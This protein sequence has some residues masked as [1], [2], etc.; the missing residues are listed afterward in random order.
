M[1]DN[2][3]VII[4]SAKNEERYIEKA[5]RSVLAQTKL[6]ER[7]VIVSDGSTDGTD[8]IILKYSK[9]NSLISYVRRESQNTGRDF[10]SKVYALQL[11]YKIMDTNDYNFIGHLDADISL[12]DDYYEKI[13]D[14]FINKENLGLA[15]GFVYEPD[16]CTFSRLKFNNSHSVPGAVQ[17]FRRRCYEEIGAFLPLR[18]GGEDW[19]AE[20]KSRMLGWEVQSYP[21]LKVYHHKVGRTRGTMKE[22]I[23]EGRMDYTLG[24]HPIYEIMKCLSRMKQKPYI[25]SG[26][27]RLLSFLYGYL[28][29][30]KR[31]VADD[32]VQYL[33]REQLMQI[34]NLLS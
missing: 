6:P 2:K 1:T 16:K 31:L 9:F 7:W 15:G 22:I 32:F 18:H 4:T 25:V 26:F 19:Y 34:L 10:S 23:R 24:S 21:A 13:I 14:I 28:E 3:Y 17:L 20:V 8:D 29:R 11:G 27:V 33:R 30:E 5:L 12:D